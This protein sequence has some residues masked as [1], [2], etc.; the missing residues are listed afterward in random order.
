MYTLRRHVWYE[1]KY[2]EWVKTDEGSG[3]SIA[4]NCVEQKEKVVFIQHFSVGL[5]IDHLFLWKVIF[6]LYICFI[7][8]L[9]SKIYFLVCYMSV[10]GPLSQGRFYLLSDIFTLHCNIDGLSIKTAAKIN[11]GTGP[12]CLPIASK[13]WPMNLIQKYAHLSLTQWI[14]SIHFYVNLKHQNK[15]KL[16]NKCLPSL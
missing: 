11:T 12:C 15:L 2:S 1:V 13:P 3:H 5:L 9:L 8:F 7:F 14:T 16:S 10:S 4:A 6:C